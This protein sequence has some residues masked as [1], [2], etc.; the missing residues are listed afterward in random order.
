M[1]NREDK[2]SHA[3]FNLPKPQVHA[4]H[5]FKNEK[6]HGRLI[7]YIKQR[8]AQDDSNRNQRVARYAQ[9]D[10]DVAA[11]MKLAEEDRKRKAKHER[12]GSP[13]PTDISLPLTWVHIDD[14][15]TYYAQTFAPNRGM[16]YHTSDPNTTE[17]AQGLIRLMNSHA[18]YGSYYRQLLRAIFNILKYNCG[19]IRTNWATEMGP[20]LMMDAEGRTQVGEQKI[21]AGNLIHSL[22][23]Y[24][25]FYDPA[26]EPVDLHKEGEWFAWAE[27][28]SHYWLKK[29]CLDGVYFNCEDILNAENS[30]WSCEY[31]KDPPVEAKLGDAYSNSEA[32]GTINWYSFMSGNDSVLVNNAFE[33]VTIQI[34]INPNDFGLIDGDRETRRARNRYEVWEFTM[35]NGDRI[36]NATYRN[37]I[38]GHLP[39]YFGSLNDDG[40]RE[41][42]KSSAEIL[43][44]LQ[45]FSSFLLNSHVK[46]TRKNLFGSTF[47]DPSR[48]D[49]DAVPTGEVAAR[50]PVKPQ[51]Y[52]SD[53]R[54]MVYHD[55]NPLDTRQTLDDLESMIGIINQFFPTQSLPSQ[56]AGIDRAVNSQVAAVQQGTNRRQHKGARLIDDTMMR[57]MRYSLYYNIMQY[58][59]DEA[60][61]ADYFGGGAYKV[62][63]STLRESSIVELIGQG[64]KALDRQ[65]IADSMQ[66]IIFAM[67]QAPQA[68]QGIDLLAMLD[69]W[70]SMQD[71]EV[72]MKQFAIPPDQ[73]NI[74]EGGTAVGADGNPIQPANNP[75]GVTE[76]IYG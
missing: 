7:E 32:G 38:H 31:Y 72:N 17:Q 8:L 18:I 10:R 13:Q 68:A 62:D 19:G 61:I 74:P 2:I 63:L 49:Y 39:A 70:T 34:R 24:N 1:Y 54:T 36:I 65:A 69:F 58:Q 44:P 75:A 12:D 14:M 51:G 52:G 73:Q 53:I 67:I 22:D 5:P 47:Y 57:P 29:R 56:I 45:G 37:N 26:V 11:W 66:S 64:L 48:V 16:F 6:N 30:T 71:V 59:E 55:N 20:K 21:F 76:P 9:I 25:L 23:M 41:A 33:L 3:R 35:V 43:N 40:M 4:S 50:I 15:M 28:K 60:D 46:A 27:M 42:T